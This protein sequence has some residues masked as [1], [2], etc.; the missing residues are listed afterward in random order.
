MILKTIGAYVVFVLILFLI[1]CCETKRGSVLE[2]K[3][4]RSL[5]PTNKPG[6]VPL[7]FTIERKRLG[8]IKIGMRINEADA[9]CK[10]LQKKTVEA[11]LYGYDGGGEAYLYHNG[12][13]DVFALIP[14]ADTDTILAIVVLDSQLKMK[15]GLGPHSTIS[16]LMRIYPGIKLYYNQMMEWESCE[17]P[18]NELSFVFATTPENQ[19][20]TYDEDT[21]M[22]S[23]KNKRPDAKIDWIVIK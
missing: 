15:N 6:V 4:F 13:Q 2:T 22:P 17:D 5:R 20:G 10:Q 23:T 19:I 12:D 14:W 18:R 7:A 8:P 9:H 21:D 16:T 11:W 3:R 1:V